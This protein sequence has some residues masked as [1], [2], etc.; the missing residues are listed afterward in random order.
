MPKLSKY[1]TYLRYNH[2]FPRDKENKR[3]S[4]LK[5]GRLDYEVLL[6]DVLDISPSL[7]INMKRKRINWEE[8]DYVL[9]SATKHKCKD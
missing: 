7:V 5:A 1:R 8:Y 9:V 3:N 4:Q 2:C 6:G